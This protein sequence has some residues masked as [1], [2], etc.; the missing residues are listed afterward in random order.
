MSQTRW[1]KKN[2]IIFFSTCPPTDNYIRIS[3]YI[4]IYKYLH[5]ILINMPT[6]LTFSYTE[7]RYVYYVCVKMNVKYI[8]VCVLY[9]FTCFCVCMSECR[10]IPRMQPE[11]CIQT[12]Q[13]QDTAPIAHAHTH[14]YKR[15]P[16][17]IR[18]CCS[19]SAHPIHINALVYTGFVVLR[20]WRASK[21]SSTVGVF[22]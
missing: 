15:T 12:R 14:P 22:V 3:L 18:I 17:A 4:H 21:C 13:R 6:K 5:F 2:S 19:P 1:H 8:Y 20:A 7:Y 16:K 11:C 9:I 10:I